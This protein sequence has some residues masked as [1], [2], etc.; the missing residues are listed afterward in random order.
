[1]RGSPD[2]RRLGAP[3]A[4]G[5]E[6]PQAGD[7]R[8]AQLTELAD[9][10]LV[11]LAAAAPAERHRVLGVMKEEAGQRIAARIAQE[12]RPPALVGLDGAND[13]YAALAVE[14][15]VEPL[16]L[17]LAPSRGQIGRRHHDHQQAGPA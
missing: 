7:E 6:F 9:V 16:P 8:R 12:V 15:L 17:V 1:M 11:L 14:M 10:V 13:E 2:E 4:V 5:A 3:F